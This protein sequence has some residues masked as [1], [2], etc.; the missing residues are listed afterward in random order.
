MN[1]CFIFWELVEREWLPLRVYET[2]RRKSHRI[3]QRRLPTDV[4]HVG[5]FADR[6]PQSVSVSNL[7]GLAI[8]QV[9]VGNA[10]SRGNV[11]LEELIERKVLLTSFPA[12]TRGAPA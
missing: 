3:G 10:I 9:V 4:K 7:N 12:F 2:S 11:E 8:K 5:R 6:C 1:T